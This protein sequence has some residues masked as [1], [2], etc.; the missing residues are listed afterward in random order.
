ME[1]PDPGHLAYLEQR[2][3]NRFYDHVLGCFQVS[4]LTINDLSARTG[5]RREA[6]I[7]FLSS[8]NDWTVWTVARVLTCIAGGEVV[9]TVYDGEITSLRPR[10]ASRSEQA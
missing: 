6:I 3:V 10:I 9:L 7:D 8:P 4:G 2:A 1:E 5:M